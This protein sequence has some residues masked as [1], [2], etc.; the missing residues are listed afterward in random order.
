[1]KYLKSMVYVPFRQVSMCLCVCELCFRYSLV[2][3]TVTNVYLEH[4]YPNNPVLIVI[5]KRIRLC[6]FLLFHFLLD[7]GKELK[8]IKAMEKID[9]QFT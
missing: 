5:M 7:E 9:S 1:M 8:V 2:T 3:I 4:H 6:K